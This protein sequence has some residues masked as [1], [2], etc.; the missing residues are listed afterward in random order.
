MYIIKR[1]KND[2]MSVIFVFDASVIPNKINDLSLFFRV[3]FGA[4]RHMCLHWFVRVICD[5]FKMDVFLS[6]AVELLLL[7]CYNEM[8]R[9]Y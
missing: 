6:A 7:G 3:I 8:W 9:F 5:V 2:N 4:I 1:E